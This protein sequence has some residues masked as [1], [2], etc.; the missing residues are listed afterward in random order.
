MK[1]SKKYFIFEITKNILIISLILVFFIKNIA[2]YT[3]GLSKTEVNKVGKYF[4]YLIIDKNLNSAD[5]TYKKI[6]SNKLIIKAIK[7]SDSILLTSYF[8]LYNADIIEIYDSENKIFFSRSNIG[9]QNFSKKIQSNIIKNLMSNKEIFYVGDS[10]EGIYCLKKFTI[11]DNEK[12]IWKLILGFNI[13]KSQ[14][15]HEIN[16]KFGL[17]ATIFFMD[18]RVNT[19]VKIN[20]R[21]Q[22]GSILDKKIS[23]EIYEKNLIYNNEANV[24]GKQYMSVYIPIFND[25]DSRGAIFIG[26]VMSEVYAQI[27]KISLLL[28]IFT[29]ATTIIVSYFLYFRVKNKYIN[30][31]I[32]VDEQIQEFIKNE[33][34]IEADINSDEIISLKESFLVMKD[35]I[36]SYEKELKYRIYHDSLTKLKNINYLNEEYTCSD[37]KNN[38]VH[39]KEEC[40]NCEKKSIFSLL[41]INIDNISSI[42]RTLGSRIGDEV[43]LKVSKVITDFLSP[44]NL[45][46]YKYVGNKFIIILP[47]RTL[48]SPENILNL[49]EESFEFKENMLSISLSIGICNTENS[50]RNIFEMLKNANIALNFAK[51]SSINKIKYFDL[52]M[53][54][55]VNEAFQIENDLKKGLLENQ[56]YL[57]YQPKIDLKSKKIVGFEALI[58]WK[59]PTKGI[60]P[61]DKFIEIAES[62]GIIIQLGKWILKESILFINNLNKNRTNK[63]HIS[64]NISIIQ[65]I[66]E[67]F[68]DFVED[69]IKNNNIDG[70]FIHFEITESVLIKSYE[71][72]ASK[73]VQLRNLGIKIDLDDFGTGYSSLNH[74]MSLPIDSLK[75]DKS[76]V[77]NIFEKNSFILEIINIGKRIGLVV[78][79]EGVE[80]E[81]HLNLLTEYDCDI[82]QGYI[83][84]KPLS[85]E[86]LIKYLDTY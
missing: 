55:K 39:C 16:D 51:D 31:I 54:N 82:I 29:L 74:L 59:H 25:G 58:R 21:L 80:T 76:F 84:S 5:N 68:N 15:I 67:D 41:L 63:L 77:D 62:T 49:F 8:T 52:K 79:A 53:S 18:T 46:L 71:T 33:D 6:I 28:I 11:K 69:F 22:V 24:L 47:H 3:I 64:I 57:N 70:N 17:D 72:I 50:Y 4:S 38:N 12:N 9:N 30:T 60:I 40:S 27:Y 36:V 66:Q 32:D 26:K 45:E 20:Q 65:L 1:L 75:I 34:K 81:N 43:L 7:D 23:S 85:E 19:S 78:V 13:S 2:N 86:E 37:Y 48:F 56:F 61:P 10:K 83:F 73:L 35:S 44:F 14:Y 42:N